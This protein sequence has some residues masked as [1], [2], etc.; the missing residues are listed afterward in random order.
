MAGN[1]RDNT[2][3]ACPGRRHFDVEPGT[4]GTARVFCRDRRC[5]LGADVVAIHYFNLA[6]GQIIETRVIARQ[7]HLP[8]VPVHR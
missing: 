7:G 1:A 8:R 4:I 6:T 3:I 2:L 5:T